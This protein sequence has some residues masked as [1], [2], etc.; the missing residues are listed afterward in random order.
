MQ[1]IL[2]TLWDAVLAHPRDLVLLLII[3]YQAWRIHML[4]QDSANWYRAWRNK[5][6][7]LRAAKQR[8]AKANAK[9]RAA[10]G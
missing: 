4:Q 3:G 5:A 1:S 2:N 7:Q 9:V 10:K 8:A 6:Q